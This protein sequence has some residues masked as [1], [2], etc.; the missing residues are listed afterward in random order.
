MS[1]KESRSA[2]GSTGGV[3]RRTVIAGAAWALPVIA[4]ASPAHAYSASGPVTATGCAGKLPG[5]SCSPPYFMQGFRVY[6]NVTNPPGKTACIK[7]TAV[8]IGNGS[9]W[10]PFPAFQIYRPTC[11]TVPPYG[12][13]CGGS[14]TNSVSIPPGTSLVFAIDALWTNS[15]NTNIKV[16]Y[17]VGNANNC[18]EPVMYYELITTLGTDSTAGDCDPYPIPKGY[19][20]PGCKTLKTLGSYCY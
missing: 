19:S 13:C 3:R 16:E 5:G 4:I 14:A 17:T 12:A 11:A 10:T 8:Y 15:G 20:D 2:P 7:I 6:L 1:I 18:S 9:T